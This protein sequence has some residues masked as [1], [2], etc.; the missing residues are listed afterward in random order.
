MPQ[1]KS[2]TLPNGEQ[3]VRSLDSQVDQVA[4]QLKGVHLFW[5]S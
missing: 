4:S 1:E 5:F 3:V 2:D